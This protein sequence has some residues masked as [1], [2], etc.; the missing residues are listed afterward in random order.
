MPIFSPTRP[1][2]I[3]AIWT[4]NLGNWRSAEIWTVNFFWWC[5]NANLITIFGSNCANLEDFGDQFFDGL[6]R[7]QFRWFGLPIWTVNFFDHVTFPFLVVTAP[8]SKILETNFFDGLA[9]LEFWRFGLPISAFHVIGNSIL[10]LKTAFT[11]FWPPNFFLRI[12]PTP[13]L[14]GFGLPIA[15]AKSKRKVQFFWQHWKTMK[16]SGQ[17]VI[18]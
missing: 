15:S 6:D 17:C 16:E 3:L 8:I 5:I 2:P 14:A 18:D 9:R 12:W 4:T 7:L 13:I 10:Q 1:T 11:S